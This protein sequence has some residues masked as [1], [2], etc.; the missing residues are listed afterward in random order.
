MGIL[1]NMCLGTPKTPFM[2]FLN[3][4]NS[5]SLSHGFKILEMFAQKKSSAFDQFFP[6]S[7]HWGKVDAVVAVAVA[8]VGI[9]S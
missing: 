3:V 1:H 8:A 7:D 2:D 9:H 4:S 5:K 6:K